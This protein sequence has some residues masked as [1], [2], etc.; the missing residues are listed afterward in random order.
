MIRRTRASRLTLSGLLLLAA[1]SPWL[2]GLH[3]QQIDSSRT[4]P[5]R[6]FLPDDPLLRDDD[7][8]DIKPVATYELSKSYD[9][10]RHTFSDAATPGRALNV[11]T[12]GEVPD[13]SWFTNRIGQRDMMIEE[14]PTTRT[15]SSRTSAGASCAGFESLPPG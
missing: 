13:S 5:G 10:L 15:T 4:T 12:L 6:R 1:A 3:A 2:S 8:R 14:V 11:N 7:M 9:F